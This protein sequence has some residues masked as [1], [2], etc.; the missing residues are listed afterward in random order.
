MTMMKVKVREARTSPQTPM[1]QGPEK[2]AAMG[3]GTLSESMEGL[4]RKCESSGAV[5]CTLCV[6]YWKVKA[7]RDAQER[8]I[9]LRADKDIW[10]GMEMT[11]VQSCISG[12]VRQGSEAC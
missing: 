10:G 9:E 6:A 12:C 11:E 2:A 7:R 4:Q 5:Y 3:L 8:Q 1:R